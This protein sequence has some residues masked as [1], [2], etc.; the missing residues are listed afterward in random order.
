MRVVALSYLFVA[1]GGALGAIARY[2]LNVA[3][4]R[5]FFFPWGTLSANL[6]GCLV[7]LIPFAILIIWTSKG[8]INMSW[9]I[10]ETS[11]D[12]LMRD[13]IQLVLRDESR[14]ALLQL[15]VGA[16]AA[17][18]DL[19]EPGQVGLGLLGAQRLAVAAVPD[20]EGPVEE[21]EHARRDARAARHASCRSPR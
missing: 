12:P 11:P 18:S 7:F 16:R 6:I 13:L 10:Q 19:L 15:G 2:G 3:L 20:P 1:A 14:E 5:D 8:F 4:Q 9:A 21:G 17:R